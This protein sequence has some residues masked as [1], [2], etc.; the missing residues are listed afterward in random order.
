M[1]PDVLLWWT[2]NTSCRTRYESPWTC[3]L[4]LFPRLQQ[5]SSSVGETCI[6]LL[7]HRPGRYWTTY[8]IF[9]PLVPLWLSTPS[10]SISLLT[11][12][13]SCFAVELSWKLRQ[14]LAQAEMS[15]DSVQ[16]M[17]QPWPPG[18][19]GRSETIR[20]SPTRIK[21]NFH[22]EWMIGTSFTFTRCGASCRFSW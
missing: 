8:W 18:K 22:G 4:F 19:Q 9:F 10:G 6:C 16:N 7:N 15:C 5:N 14:A 13:F 2:S 3:V 1:H 11:L 21:S 17:W 12:A 20:S